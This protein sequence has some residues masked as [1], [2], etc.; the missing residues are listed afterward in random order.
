MQNV[1]AFILESRYSVLTFGPIAFKADRNYLSFI[2]R[3]KLV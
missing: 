2:P 1:L 3:N